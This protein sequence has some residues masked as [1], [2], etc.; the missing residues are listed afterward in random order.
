MKCDDE[1]E[2]MMTAR[3][4]KIR[5]KSNKTVRRVQERASKNVDDP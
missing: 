3:S 5:I 1:S 4:I 2:A